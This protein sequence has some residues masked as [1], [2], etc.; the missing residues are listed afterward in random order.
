VAGLSYF[1]GAVY[2]LEHRKRLISFLLMPR[3][4]S[5]M[6]EEQYQPLKPENV[7]FTDKRN[8]LLILLESVEETYNDA[9]LFGEQLMPGLARLRAEHLS[10]YGS[11]ETT[12]AD[13]TIGVLTA[14]T[15]GLPMAFARESSMANYFGEASDIFLPGA[16]S[17]LRILEEHGYEIS[18]FLGSKKTFSGKDKLFA[19]HSKA[20]AIYDRQYF[21]EKRQRGEIEYQESN[22]GVPDSFMYAE[23]KDYLQNRRGSGPFFI[24]METVDTHTGNEKFNGLIERKWGDQRDNVAEADYMVNDF[25]SWLQQQSFYENTAVIILGDHLFPLDMLGAV[26]LPDRG[27]REPY[28]VFINTGLQYSGP[29]RKFAAFDLAPTM[30]AAA[31]AKWSGGRLGLGLSLFETGSKTLFENKG[32]NYYEEEVRKKSSF[33]DSLFRQ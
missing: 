21:E 25:V 3:E 30:L 2:Y 12:G 22:W 26:E 5:A 31:G 18:F 20:A 16:S 11:R 23:V 8:V 1:I 29:K 13:W 7:Q 10:F 9:T 28:N 14:Y 32:Q 6:F 24:I 4:K 19:S 17:T 15:M 33:Y 27:Q